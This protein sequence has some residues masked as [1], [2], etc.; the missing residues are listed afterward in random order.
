MSDLRFQA[1]TSTLFGHC[2]HTELSFLGPSSYSFFLSLSTPNG[3]LLSNK[4]SL[5]FSLSI[6]AHL[7]SIAQQ[8]KQERRQQQQHERLQIST[9]FIPTKTTCCCSCCCCCYLCLLQLACQIQLSYYVEERPRAP[10]VY[11]SALPL[12]CS[13]YLQIQ[14][15]SLARSLSLSFS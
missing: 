6:R 7:S 4:C 5:S 10:C 2:L 15:R 13:P 12:A 9:S 14:L 3:H 11:V 8:A 1:T